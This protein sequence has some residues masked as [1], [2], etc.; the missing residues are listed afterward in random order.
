M[1]FVS[2]TVAGSQTITSNYGLYSNNAGTL[3][4]ISSNSFSLGLSVSSVSA[5]ISYPTA[6]ATSGYAYGTVTASGTAQAH[7]LFGTVGNKIVGLQ[8]GNSMTLDE[9]LYYIGLHQR[10]STSS[11]AVGVST[12]L[13]GNVMAAA[14]NVAPIGSAS[15]AL[16]GNI[17]YHFG[18]G[19]FTSTGSAGHSGTNLLAAMAM[20]NLAQTLTVMPMLTFI[21]T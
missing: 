21:S 14:Q 13:A 1:S 3:S 12:A 11:A 15:S 19:A 10:Q 6:T 5:T 17:S 20:S 4:L 16:T 8:F 2:S 9:G 7:S 18:W